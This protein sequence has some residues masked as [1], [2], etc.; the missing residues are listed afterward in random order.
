MIFA[1]VYPEKDQDLLSLAEACLSHPDFCVLQ[2]P[3]FDR[4]SLS[5]SPTR[6]EVLV[7]FVYDAV[8]LSLAAAPYS[9]STVHSCAK[10]SVGRPAQTYGAECDAAASGVRAD[11]GGY[12]ECG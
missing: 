3:A 10:Q 8:F 4:P 5:F 9:F 7:R 1:D 12:E 2:T 6:D 11:S